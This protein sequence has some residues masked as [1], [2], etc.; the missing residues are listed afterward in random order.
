MAISMEERNDEIEREP[1]DIL[2]IIVE[3]EEVSMYDLSAIYE[4]EAKLSPDE[5]LDK[6]T[7]I[8]S[9]LSGRGLVELRL[10]LGDDG[11]ETWIRPTTMAMVYLKA[12][13]ILR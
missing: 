9:T 6:I 12:H 1:G 13:E 3:E 2:K 5:S 8:V 7:R 10:E 4:A 11:L